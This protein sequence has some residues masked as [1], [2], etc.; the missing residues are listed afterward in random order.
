MTASGVQKLGCGVRLEVIRSIPTDMC[1]MM[2]AG[3]VERQFV[4]IV[5]IPKFSP[6]FPRV[7]QGVMA[8]RSHSWI[9]TCLDMGGSKLW[10]C[11][12]FSDMGRSKLL[13]CCALSARGG[14]KP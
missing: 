13:E 2:L 7:W 6:I 1:N 10:K 12:S 5:C 9:P 11:C 14:P 8:V 4:E 3:A